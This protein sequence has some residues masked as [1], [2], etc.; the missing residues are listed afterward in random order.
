MNNDFSP[1]RY[2]SGQNP[3]AQPFNPD[4]AYFDDAAPV[5][6]QPSA[7]WYEVSCVRA[8]APNVESHDAVRSLAFDPR[9]E[10]IWVGT[11]SGMLHSHHATDMSRVVST[12]VTE[13]SSDLSNA[14]DVRDIVVSESVVMAAVGYGLA[15][16]R[17]GGA[18]HASV[19]ADTV[20][21][22]KAIALNPLTH[23]HVCIGGDS[24]MLAVIDVAQARIVRQASLRGATGVTAACW[25]APE[26]SCNLA[27]F[28]TATGR[29][30]FCDPS[31]MREVNAAAAFT[32]ATTA[33]SSSG[34]YL[35]ATGLASRAGVSYLE[36]HVKVFDIRA[37]DNPLPSVMFPAPPM[38][39]SFDRYTAATCNSDS[40]IWVLAP[41]GLMQLLD[42][43]NI[44]SGDPAYPLSEQIQLDAGA[45]ILTSMAVSS[46]GVL[47]M[48]D[49]GGF[50]H[51][52]A[53]S[54]TVKVNE[55]S[56]PI[57]DAPVPAHP[58]TPSIRLD[59][60]MTS[61]IGASIPKCAIPEFDNGYI[62]DELFENLPEV[63]KSHANIP[64]CSMRK[65]ADPEPHSVLYHRQPFARFP[66][67]VSDEI[68]N[69]AQQ[70]QSIVGYAQAPSS[71]VRNS[72]VGHKKAPFV[73]GMRSTDGPM[74]R[75]KSVSG[76]ANSD[77]AAARRRT[78]K[79]DL[80]KPAAKSSFVE[81]DL[82]AWESI[83]GFN[84]LQYNKSGLF[85]GLENA[86]PNVYVNSVV[87]VL[88][89][90]PPIRKAVGDH[91]CDRDWCIS[92]E[93]GFLFHM[94]DLGGAGM[95]CEAGNFTRAFMTMANAGALGLLDGAHALPLSQR[96]ENFSRYLLEQLHKDDEHKTESTVSSILGA[97]TVSYGS[98]MNSGTKW[99]RNSRP[100]QHTLVY[101]GV[102][103]KGKATS[104]CELVEQ[105]LWQ[106]LTPTRAF[107]E[108][109]QQFETMTQ[110]RE[111]RSL[112][113]FLLLGCN[114]KAR[115]YLEWWLGEEGARLGQEAAR[116]TGLDRKSSSSEV[117]E[118]AI[119]VMEREKK[120]VESMRVNVSD[121]MKVSELDQEDA[122]FGFNHDSKEEGEGKTE[123]SGGQY[124]DY[125]LSFVIVHVAPNFGCDGDNDLSVKNGQN[126]SGHLVAY[127]RVPEEYRVKGDGQGDAESEW[128]CFNDFVISKCVGFEE[129]SGFDFAWKMPC[130]VGYVRRDIRDRAEEKWWD[131]HR[132][133]V[134]VREVLGE[135]G[136]NAAVGLQ[137]GEEA[138]GK[139]S[140]LGLDC[141]FVMVSREEAD[142]FADGTKQVVIPGR[143]A[144]ARVSV[145]RGYGDL[146]GK[147]LI[148][149]YVAVREPVV[150]Y[151]T[152]FSGVAEGDLQV[153]RSKYAVS[154]LKS[155]YKRLRCLVDAGCVFVGHGLKSDFRIINF[156]VPPE[157]VIDTVTIFRMGNKRLL[158]LRFL[159]HALLGEDIQ[160]ETHDSIE[161]SNAA[162]GLYDL[163]V[164]LKRDRTG[165]A[166]I[167][168][169]GGDGR[170]DEFSVMLK[171]LY[172][173]GY[174]NNWK[175]IEKEPFRLGMVQRSDR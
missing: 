148:D 104:F 169:G 71:F 70:S 125:D 124:A 96:I 62:T 163:Y 97:N 58:P 116:R 164:E 26:A 106:S 36:Q 143:K 1:N 56:E 147:A 131:C 47:V 5:E 84:F 145:I 158:G 128:W 10:L 23:S 22:A 60:L 85:C 157:Q 121:G 161:D 39:V 18:I 92:C 120:L 30:S 28:S 111:L 138:P 77:A 170:N 7:A 114:T 146:Q 50:V 129:V 93:L 68:R 134:N 16:V 69:R 20:K 32:G 154:S 34:Y 80:T 72:E 12:Y 152:R 95:A 172:A 41:N 83:E 74:R 53:S 110:R 38:F 40:A 88:Y 42:I 35:A 29:I 6:P 171:D 17:R 108:A 66:L 81:M 156:V 11:A 151:L 86:L 167:A 173:Y 87:Q 55:D 57:W 24:R 119:Q 75:S 107:C 91:V 117:D 126:V 67:L 168:N 61:E 89:F 165:G 144:L 150:D 141:E 109:S 25:A 153:G 142:I 166:N 79:L 123:E 101:D 73:R 44:S 105:S 49:S 140:L 64:L 54:E 52:W 78:T 155:V 27:I 65:V 132:N 99:E 15:I 33:L 37:I 43:S 130:L 48:G 2:Q 160:G 45:D 76:P 175:V 98:F 159:S 46:Q 112:P 14:S 94:F 102:K 13:P 3:N 113:N 115:G 118:M 100:F 149:D 139:G 136:R 162:L 63:P 21:N 59:V 133:K 82:V 137:E 8:G 90:S 127:I 51:Q 174:R 19:R 9:K 135:E 31:T 122:T 4:A 103:G